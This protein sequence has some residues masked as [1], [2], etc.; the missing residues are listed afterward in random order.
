M[1]N[2]PR[3]GF[4][5]QPFEAC[6]KCQGQYRRE[7]TFCHCYQCCFEWDVRDPVEQVL[8]R[9]RRRPQGE[10]PGHAFWDEWLG[11]EEPELP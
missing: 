4:Q 1:G 2:L 7:G 6:P 11:S 10:R 8:A 5:P 3:E 9:A